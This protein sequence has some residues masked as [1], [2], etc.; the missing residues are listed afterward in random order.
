VNVEDEQVVAGAVRSQEPNP[1]VELFIQNARDTRIEVAVSFGFAALPRE[2]AGQF[3]AVCPEV[4]EDGR[5]G[6]AVVSACRVYSPQ[7]S[8]NTCELGFAK[9]DIAEARAKQSIPS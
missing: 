9:V 8:A 6:D 1:T 3:P 5:A 7:A 4:P 2:R